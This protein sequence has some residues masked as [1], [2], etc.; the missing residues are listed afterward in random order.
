[1]IQEEFKVEI[2]QKPATI[3]DEIYI[4]R[5]LDNRQIEV[6]YFENGE[7]VIKRCDP[8]D[9]MPPSMV[10]PTSITRELIQAFTLVGKKI[11]VE[12]PSESKAQGMLEAQ[13]KH[14]EDLRTLLKLK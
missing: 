2:R 6:M 3:D 5:V 8:S 14:L 7:T 9:C 10:L 1:M 4:Y 13:S 11:G 12:V